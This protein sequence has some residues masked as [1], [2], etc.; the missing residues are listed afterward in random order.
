MADGKPIVV[1]MDSFA[2]G[3]PVKPK[4]TAKDYFVGPRDMTHFSKWPFVLRVHGSIVPHILIP[5]LVVAIWVTSV[6]CACKFH[7]TNHK[8]DPI[9]LTVLGFIVGLA[10]SFRS[11]TAYERY[12]EGRR[13]WAQLTVTSQN[14][15][16][17]V[18]VHA[19]EREGE[20]GKVDLLGKVT[21]LN[22]IVAFT[23]ALKHRVRFEPYINYDDLRGRVQFLET[24]AGAA[25]PGFNVHES[26]VPP[27][28]RFGEFLGVP[29]AKSNPR[30]QIKRATQP[31]GNLPL[32]ILV[33]LQTYFDALIEA[34]QLKVPI[35][36]VQTISALSTLNEIATGCDR[37]L[38]TPL[39]IAYSIA[40][41]QIT[42]IYI[43]LLPFMLY[44]KLGWT[45]IPA[46]ILAAYIIL[47]MALIGTEIENP[48]GE[49]VNDLP[50]ESMC[51][52]I[53]NDVD[54]IMSRKRP[55]FPGFVKRDANAVMWPLSGCGFDE[56][57][58]R[59]EEEIREALATKVAVGWRAGH[60]GGVPDRVPG[61]GSL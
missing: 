50:L 14:L 44:A 5:M 22:L 23:V 18:W 24:Y 8:F 39:P 11:T 60:R 20:D 52:Q 7:F 48:F 36:Q 46:T 2:G 33:H 17:V 6:V 34:G 3:P 56:W 38:N 1:E 32:E 12:M 35:Y 55:A 29:F 47:G 21:A 61:S 26:R 25:S 13:Y 40:I 16:R 15:A 54:V 31:L 57:L 10:L 30:A 43:L 49:D 51:E 9:M 59:S 53:A 19:R 4:K 27:L 58:G 41:S 37:I 45:T 28:K 42:W